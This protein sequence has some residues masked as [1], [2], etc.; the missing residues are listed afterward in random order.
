MLNGSQRVQCPP[1]RRVQP[2]LVRR[3]R[4]LVALVL[5]LALILEVALVTIWTEVAPAESVWWVTLMVALLLLAPSLQNSWRIIESV[6]AVVVGLPER[7]ARLAI[8]RT[9]PAEFKT[10]V[11]YPVLISDERDIE[12]ALS[13]VRYNR[14]VAPHRN[15]GFIIA[16][17]C[18][19]GEE[20]DVAAENALH[21]ELLR[22]IEEL[23]AAESDPDLGPVAVVVR[24]QRWNS[25]E[26]VWMGWERKRGNIMDLCAMALGE[27]DHY[28]SDAAARDVIVGTK[29][30]MVCDNGTLLHDHTIKGLLGVM[31]AE[32]VDA[33][34]SVE[35]RTVI[36]QP[37]YRVWFPR[38]PNRYQRMLFPGYENPGRGQ[39]DVQFSMM[40]QVLDRDRYGGQALI[41]VELFLDQVRDLIPENIALGHDKLEA[42]YVRSRYVTDAIILGKPVTSYYQHRTRLARWIRGDMQHL[43]WILGKESPPGGLRPMDRLVMVLDIAGPVGDIAAVCLLLASWGLLRGTPAIVATVA[44][45]LLVSGRLIAAVVFPLSQAVRALVSRRRSATAL[46]VAGYGSSSRPILERDEDV[47]STKRLGAGLVTAARSAGAALGHLGRES[48]T[49]GVQ[50]MFLADRAMYSLRSICLTLWRLGVTHRGLMEWKHSQEANRAL[51]AKASLQPVREMWPGVLLSA[52]AACWF[53]LAPVAGVYAF[54]LLGVWALTPVLAAWLSQPTARGDEGPSVPLV[55]S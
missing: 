37:T 25:V 31:A 43:P 11:V 49:E 47:T 51:A 8:G 15:L 6:G 33:N 52:A 1:H 50:V 38:F 39:Q 19:D 12:Q 32:A 30:F 2:H 42:T 20:R 41:A 9:I 48:M 46:P 7:R 21:R 53:L 22:R 45:P 36:A 10:A 18:P 16:A 29:Y 35:P 55:A 40:Q 14:R 27:G 13:C 24:R 5:L 4:R 44:I 26:R 23:N 17:D 54:A 3:E 34:G 28:H